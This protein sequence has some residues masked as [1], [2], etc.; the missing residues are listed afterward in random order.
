MK[1]FILKREKPHEQK[2]QNI[3]NFDFLAQHQ[4]SSFMKLL[5]SKTYF[6]KDNSKSYNDQS[7]IIWNK[8]R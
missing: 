6:E 3:K 7:F 5:N 2:N 1:S 4:E 8:K